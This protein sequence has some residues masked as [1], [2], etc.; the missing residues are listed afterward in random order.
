MWLGSPSSEEKV[1]SSWALR[2]ALAI[3]CLFVL[4]LGVVPGAFVGIAQA[5]VRILGS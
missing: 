5:A 3:C 2:T 4:I 1:P